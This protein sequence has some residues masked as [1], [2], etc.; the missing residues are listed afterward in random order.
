MEERQVRLRAEINASGFYGYWT[1][2]LGCPFPWGQFGE[3]PTVEGPMED[4][5]CIGDVFRIGLARLEV[6]QP[7][8]PCFKLAMKMQMEEF[9]DRFAR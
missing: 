7:R 6:T 4:E 3:N 1:E 2:Q 8:W 5:V 9:I